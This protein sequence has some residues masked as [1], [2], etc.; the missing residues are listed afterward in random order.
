M[1]EVN[2]RAS[3]TVPFMSKV[4]G[5]P[6]VRLAT[7]IMLGQ[8]LHELGYAPGLWPESPL[9]AVKAPVFSMAK[10]SGVDTFLGPEMK[11]TGEVMG[12]DTS[13]APALHKAMVSAGLGIPAIGSVLMSIADRHKAECG[14]IARAFADNGYSL[15]ATSGTARYLRS[16]GLEVEQ[17]SRLRDGD[18]TMID[19]IRQGRTVLVINTL[20]GDRE[21]L[22]DGFHMRRAAAESQVPCLTSIDTARA[23]ADAIGDEGTA[24]RV[25]P[26][27]T[28]RDRDDADEI[29]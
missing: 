25:L 20:T 16:L 1:I 23:L 4:T 15:L 19:N 8:T 5:V 7:R 6:M 11:S 22:Q 3:R 12:V 13:F 26:L 2:P 28:Y 18:N 14:D 29:P 21:T 10:L 17:V 9:V 27:A 24:F